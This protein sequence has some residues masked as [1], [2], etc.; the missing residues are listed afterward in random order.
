M[1]GDTAVIRR[2][3]R[4]LQGAASEVRTQAAG[5]A[6]VGAVAWKSTAA[7]A[8]IQDLTERAAE[9]LRAAEQLDEAAAALDAHAVAVDAVK[10]AIEA[11]ARWVTDRRDEAVHLVGNAV[12]TVLD[13]VGMVFEFFGRVVPRHL[14]ERA[15]DILAVTTWL[16]APGSRDW[17]DLA[18]KF[19]LRGLS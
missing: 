17:L 15:Q 5:L 11:S 16:P 6:D 1:Y 19:R 13:G 12:E 14:V 18:E 2:R 10:A 8:F 4:E 9:L 7:A 3:A